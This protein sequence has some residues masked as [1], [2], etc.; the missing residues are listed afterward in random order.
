[1]LAKAS[2]N[3]TDLPNV[4]VVGQSPGKNVSKKADDIAEIR[5]QATIREDIAD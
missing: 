3:L 2:S 5:H 4:L 1:M